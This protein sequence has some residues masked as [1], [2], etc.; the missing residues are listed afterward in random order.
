MRSLTLL[1][2]SLAVLLSNTGWGADVCTENCVERIVT[3]FRGK[4]PFKRTVERVPAIE[5]AQVEIIESEPVDMVEVRTIEYRGKPPFKRS[6]ELV[7]VV[8]IMQ[9]EIDSAAPVKKSRSKK[10]GGRPPFRR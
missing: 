8:D 6:T 5:I 2:G 1:A 9:V 3:D 10:F 7:P 4:P